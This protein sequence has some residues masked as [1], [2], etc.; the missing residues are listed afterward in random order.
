VASGCII[1][2]IYYLDNQTRRIRWAKWLRR[3]NRGWEDNTKVDLKRN[4][5]WG[6]GLGS[7]SSGRGL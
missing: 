2:N 3:F 1:I 4:R 7:S 5:T 6:S